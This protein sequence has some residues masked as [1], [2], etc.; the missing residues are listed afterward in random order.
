MCELAGAPALLHSMIGAIAAAR[1]AKEKRKRSLSA[2]PD[3]SRGKALTPGSRLGKCTMWKST[4][5]CRFGDRCAYQ[6]PENEKG[7]G[8]GGMVALDLGCMG[9]VGHI[10]SALT[11]AKSA[12]V[13]R[14]AEKSPKGVKFTDDIVMRK[15]SVSSDEWFGMELSLNGVKALHLEVL[16]IEVRV[17]GVEIDASPHLVCAHLWNWEE[18]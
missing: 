4:G 18:G 1:D 5:N 6:H 3:C 15:F 17:D 16:V 13:D 12:I 7:T 11:A 8:A 9:A 10:P 14:I 2:S